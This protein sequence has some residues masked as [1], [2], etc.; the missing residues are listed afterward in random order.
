MAATA[1]GKGSYLSALCATRH[2]L[3]PC[4]G[5]SADR[6]VSKGQPQEPVREDAALE[7]GVELVRSLRWLDL[8]GPQRNA[9]DA[10]LLARALRVVGQE[11]VLRV[12]LLGKNKGSGLAFCLSL[13]KRQDLTP[14]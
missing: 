2:R 11:A 12:A 14:A 8:V 4:P 7:E 5:R 6:A 10:E 3:F 9:F 1:V 13:G